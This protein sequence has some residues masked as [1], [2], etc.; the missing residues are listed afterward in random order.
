MK[1]DKVIG[2]VDASLIS[3]RSDAFCFSACIDWICVQKYEETAIIDCQK[4]EIMSISG[5]NKSEIAQINHK[6]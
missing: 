5:K 3:S 2:R 1:E 4:L 6:G